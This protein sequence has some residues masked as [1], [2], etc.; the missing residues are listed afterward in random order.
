MTDG[1]TVSDFQ[2]ATIAFDGDRTVTV[3]FDSSLS[4][5]FES[6]VGHTL[7]VDGQ[8]SA[9]GE[10]MG[11]SD[12]EVVTSGGDSTAPALVSGRVR[13]DAQDPANSI[14]I[15]VDE[16]LDAGDAIDETLVDI[17]G[18]NPT[19]VTQLGPRTVRA[20]W[21]APVAVSDMVNVSWQDLAGN[22]GTLSQ[23]ALGAETVG[24]FLATVS[25]TIQPGFGGDRVSIAFNEPFDLPSAFNPGNY[26]ATQGTSPVDLSLA[27][28]RY[29][30][31]TNT[32]HF[33]LPAGNELAAD[34]G[35]T[36]SASGVRDHAGVTMVPGVLSGSVSGD[37]LPPALVSGV[38]NFREDATG[39]TVDLLF[40]EDLPAALASINSSFSSSGGQVVATAAP[41]A[42][43][44]VRLT[45]ATP[46]VALDTITVGTAQMEDTSGNANPAPLVVTPVH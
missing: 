26:S 29:E 1:V 40:S 23:A 44:V 41:V 33:L 30:S 5:A 7:T 27:T 24:P 13:L 32:V 36:V 42:D 6:A 3:S 4:Q 14:L 39:R 34:S 43:H 16:A 21:G 18:A 25:G 46:L 45:L 15:E 35:V 11:A 37:T 8:E 10:A 2:N 19:L 31:S 12:V 28:A 17:L 22:L 20:T 38:V 9:Q